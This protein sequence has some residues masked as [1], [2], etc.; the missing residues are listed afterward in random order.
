MEKVNT[1]IRKKLF[2]TYYGTINY[3]QR[4]R[5]TIIKINMCKEGIFGKYTE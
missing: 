3:N 5:V 4:F 2:L 1:L